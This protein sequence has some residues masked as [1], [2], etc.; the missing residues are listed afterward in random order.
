VDEAEFNDLVDTTLEAVELALDDADGDLDYESA[1]GILT[2]TFENGSSMIFSRQSATRQLWLAARSGG[3][4][5]EWDP[6]ADDWRC[7]RTAGLLRE[8]LPAEI[9][10]QGGVSIVLS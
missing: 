10:S 5:F 1:G 9:E 8:F 2:V 3:Y 6:A 7:T 4:H